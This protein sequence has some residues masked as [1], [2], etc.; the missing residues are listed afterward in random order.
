[1]EKVILRTMSFV[2]SRW[3]QPFRSYDAILFWVKLCEPNLE[4][5]L[6]FLNFFFD[7]TDMKGG[8]RVDFHE[9]IN[10]K[11]EKLKN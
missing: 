6:E 8:W 9:K 3:L 1:M 10:K 5:L 2:W 4:H 11:F 7:A